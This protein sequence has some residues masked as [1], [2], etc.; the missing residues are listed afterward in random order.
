V[1]GL[2]GEAEFLKAA[3]NLYTFDYVRNDMIQ[4]YMPP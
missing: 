2:S 1:T 4:R 3:Q